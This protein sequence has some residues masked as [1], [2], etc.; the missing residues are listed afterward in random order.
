METSISLEPKPADA[1]GRKKVLI[2]S[3]VFMGL[4]HIL[5][6]KQYLKGFFLAAVEAVFIAFLPRITKALIN[7]QTL[8]EPKP[9]LPIRLRDNSIFMLIDGVVV[10]AAV[11][12]FIATYIIS[13]RDA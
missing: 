7:L 6:L 1:G 11:A 13:V 5:Y 2:A 10:V 8:G 3:I 4:G 12:V 9:H